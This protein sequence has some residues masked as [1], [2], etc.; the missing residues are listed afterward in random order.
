[1]TDR[2]ALEPAGPSAR[3]GA[4]RGVPMTTPSMTRH[5][6]TP[7]AW[8][9]LTPVAVVTIPKWLAV[10]TIAL[11]AV[12]ACAG[13]VCAAAALN[14]SGDLGALRRSILMDAQQK[15]GD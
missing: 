9:P 15:D 6:V 1:M 10:T 5:S 4:P 11:L 13:I 14:V 2:N 12:I 7:D 8:P 3:G